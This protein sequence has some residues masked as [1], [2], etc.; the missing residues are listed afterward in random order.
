MTSEIIRVHKTKNFS[1]IDNSAPQDEN[2]SLGATAVMVYLLTKPD[3]WQVIKKDIQ[4]RFKIGRDKCAKIFKELEANGYLLRKVR[5][6]KD[7]SFRWESHVFENPEQASIVETK[8]PLPRPEAP[9][10]KL[11]TTAGNQEVTITDDRESP[12]YDDERG[13]I[14]RWL[15]E[16]EIP[17]PENEYEWTC[18]EDPVVWNY[19]HGTQ[20]WPGWA[21]IKLLVRESEGIEPEAMS[22]AATLWTQRN[23]KPGRID[24]VIDWAQR[25]TEDPGW[26]P[27]QTRKEKNGNNS[28]RNNENSKTTSDRGNEPTPEDIEWWQ[29][30][31]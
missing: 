27:S 17:A 24:G 2:L 30:G 13:K 1:I 9:K 21:T 22:R 19:L 28:T 23:Y 25:M 26:S 8:K 10:V 4:R 18:M 20:S 14:L 5:H 16:S 12:H 6:G 31:N 29:S 3:D 15:R 11:E 7:G